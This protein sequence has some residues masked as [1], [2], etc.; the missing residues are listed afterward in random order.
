MVD[1]APPAPDV[2]APEP[3]SGRRIAWV[4]LVPIIAL[5]IALGVAWRTYSERGPLIEIRFENAAGI[6][7][8]Q[9]TLRFRDVNVG[10]VENI[11]LSTDLRSVIVSVRVRKDVARYIDAGAQFWVVRPSVTAQGVSGIETVI[12][13]VYIGAYWDDEI[14]ERQTSFVGLERA[15]LTPADQPG[16]RVRLRAPT[17][18]SMTIGAPVLFKSIQVGRIEN[19]ELTEAGDVMIDVFVNAPNHLRL[20]EG[21]RFWNASGFSINIGAG[22]ASLNVASLISLL[23]G[24]V[25]FDTV[26]SDT[27]RVEAGHVYE[28]YPSEQAARENVLGDLT[29]ARLLVDVD[30]D[31]AVRGLAPGA[32]V[33]FHGITV[34]EIRSMQAAIVREDGEERVTL[35]TTLALVPSRLGVTAQTEEEAAEQALDLLA[36]QVARGLR[37]RIAASGLLAQTLYVDLVDVPDAAPAAFQRDAEPNPRLPSVP[38]D[39]SGIAASAEGVLKRVASLPLEDLV[40]SAVTLLANVNSLVTDPRVRAAPENLGALVADLRQIVD[41]DG[42][43]GAPAEIAAILASTRSIVDEATEAQLVAQ[44]GDVLA[45]TKA[46]LES[47]GTA[48]DGVPK[49]V[50]EVEALA[51]EARALPLSELVASATR[52]VDDVDAFIESE[53]VASLP[54]S[55]EASLGELRGVVADLR[56]GGAVENVN[57]TLATVRQMTDELA[58]ARLTE[59]INRVINQASDAA[60]NVNLAAQ[61]LPELIEEAR[62]VA[63]KAQALPLSELVATGTRVLETADGLLAAPGVSDVPPNLAA[64]LEELRAILA[65]L[66]EGGAV[67]N[68]NATLASADRAADAI[69]AAADDLPALVAEIARVAEQAEAALATVGPGSEINRDTL[70]LLQEVRDAA[71]SLNSLVTALERRPNSLLFGR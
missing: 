66:R 39:V 22:G 41:S 29:G 58:A 52:L 65:E 71:R 6:E 31:G 32:A 4:W 46:S 15:P 33:E 1:E 45:S 21:T 7:P 30:F 42:I 12:S 13:G 40:E 68:V 55:V 51:A 2:E 56:T 8:G 34:G 44:L 48:A 26:G 49:L 3:E 11:Q 28:L 38:S 63:A 60:N 35:R 36:S 24:G 20:V 70:R 69:T 25:A 43:Q 61:D 37:A 5:V 50:A 19:I 17:G 14:G 59:S 16:L 53:G 67:E 62:A 47:V 10:V 64:A 57:A 27:T 18:G 23:Q 54:G 9:T